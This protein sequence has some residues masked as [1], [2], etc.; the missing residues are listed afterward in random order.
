MAQE[1]KKKPDNKVVIGPVR[2]SYLHVFEPKS[3]KGQPAKYSASLIIPKDETK[4]IAEV[5]KAIEAA[6]EMGKTN[7]WGG[8]IPKKLWNPLRDGDTEREGN[9][10]YEGAFFLTAHSDTRPGVVDKKVKPIIDQ[11][12]FYSGCWGFVSLSFFPY[13][14]NGS[15]GIGVGLNHLQKFKDDEPFSSRSSAEEDFQALQEEED[16]EE[17][18]DI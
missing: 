1:T 5:Q 9:Q 14:A 2:L 3:F 6:K 7:K 18:D 16:D 11:T 4:I 15:D 17:Y 8:K 13:S 12:E 10:P